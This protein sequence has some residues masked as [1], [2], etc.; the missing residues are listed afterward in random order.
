MELTSLITNVVL[1]A[2]FGAIAYVVLKGLGIVGTKKPAIAEITER[3]TRRVKATREHVLICGPS[4]AGKTALINYLATNEWRETVSSLEGTKAAFN[5][6]AKVSQGET[7]N[8]PVSKTLKLKYVDVPGHT[9]F[10]EEMLDAAEAASAIILLV[11]ARDQVSISHSVE[12]LYELLNTCRTVFEEKLPILIV[13]NKQ[14]LSNAKKATTLEIDLEKEMD[15]LKRV[16]V[17]TMDEDQEYQGYIESLKGS[18]EFKN[19]SDFVQIG[20]ASIKE[21]NVDE[22]TQFIVKRHL[23]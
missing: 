22:I 8:E 1:L 21:G 3:G 15:E 18:F 14:D 13:G 6:S 23:K 9:H 7:N 16:R 4:G 20:E 19:L 17:A 11:D 12:Y 10:I 2:I 5:V